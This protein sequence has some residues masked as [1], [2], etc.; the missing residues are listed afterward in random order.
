MRAWQH[1]ARGDHS[2]KTLTRRLPMILP[3]K[4]AITKH[5]EMAW[6]LNYYFI[7]QLLEIGLCWQTKS[8]CHI[9]GLKQTCI[10]SKQICKDRSYQQPLRRGQHLLSVRTFFCSLTVISLFNVSMDTSCFSRSSISFTNS[11]CL[12]SQ[13]LCIFTMSNSISSISLPSFLISSSRGPSSCPWNQDHTKAI[14]LFAVTKHWDTTGVGRHDTG[15]II[16][17]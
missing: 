16:S 4:R 6:S 17:Y 12:F 8:L 13:Y 14:V 11:F 10:S 7:L 2:V 9:K 1:F 15:I 5:C 3:K